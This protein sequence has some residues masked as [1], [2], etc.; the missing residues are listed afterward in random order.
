MNIAIIGAGNIGGTLGKKWKVMGHEIIFGVRD[1]QSSKVLSAL[2]AIGGNVQ[3]G[4]I[5]EAIREGEVILLSTPW[6]AVASLAADNAASMAGKI[7]LDATNNFGGLIINN[8]GTLQASAPT[9]RL[10]RAFN[11][12]GWEVFANPQ[13]DGVI[14]D[15]FY[16][17]PDGPS[18]QQ[19]EALIAEIGVHPIYIGDNDRVQI[20]DNLGAL[21]V[22]L[23]FRLGYER[24]LALKIIQKSSNSQ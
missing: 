1:T 18:R 14:A 5:Q 23:V 4:S 17:G 21:W 9:A 3:V 20:V 24:Q 2:A 6:N 22:T 16:C 13:I 19:V 12:L 7:I 10:Y 11:S 8:I 15:M